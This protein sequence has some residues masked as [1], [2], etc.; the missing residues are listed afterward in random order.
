MEKTTEYIG[1]S[2]FTSY[3][4]SRGHV[5]I[6]GPSASDPLDFDAGFFSDPE[7]IDV[8]KHVWAYKKQREFARRMDC[9]RGEFANWHPPFPATSGAACIDTTGPLPA[10]TPPIIYA[11]EDDAIIE[12]FIREKIMSLWHGMGTCKML[13]REKNGV[14]DETLGVHRVKGLKVADLSI[15]P[16][17]VGANTASTAFAI[18]EKAADLFIRELEL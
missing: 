17:N 13:P 4:F 6:T 3:P 18:G 1:L 15:A 16:A 7:S 11:P 5:H 10:D 9:Y 8:K 2:N 12:Q 14:V